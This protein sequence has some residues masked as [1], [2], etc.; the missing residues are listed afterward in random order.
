MS[1]VQSEFPKN[2]DAGQVRGRLFLG[3]FTLSAILAAAVTF[4][5]IADASPVD[6]L[7]GNVPWI[8]IL[9]SIL[10]AVLGMILYGRYRSVQNSEGVSGDDQLAKRFVRLFSLSAVVPALVMGV[11]LGATVTRG[12][13]TWFSDRVDVLVDRNAAIAEGNRDELIR[14]LDLDTKLFADDLAASADDLYQRKVLLEDYLRFQSGYRG[15][16]EAALITRSGERFAVASFAPRKTT[17]I[18]P[19]DVFAEAD[20]GLVA[21]TLYPLNADSMVAATLIKLEGDREHYLYLHRPFPRSIFAQLEAA[22]TAKEELDV[23]KDKTSRLQLIFAIGYA[24]MSALVLLLAARFGLGAA[25]RVT[26]PI[27]KLASA[28]HAVRD[29]DLSV[30]VT[31]P[32]GNDEVA[33]LTRSF[34]GMTEQLGAQRSA[35]IAAREDAEDRRQFVETLLSEV[36]AGVIRTDENLN[37]TLANR[38]AG[39][40]LNVALNNGD[41]IIDVAPEFQPYVSDALQRVSSIDASIDLMRDGESRHFRLKVSPDPAG[42]C[43]LTFDDATRLVSAQRQLAWRDVARRIAHE[44]RNPLTPIQLSTERL[45]RR[46]QS[47]ISQ[48]DKVF[49]RC[50]ETILRQVGDIDRMVQEFS[51]FARMPKPSV[52][53][54]DLRALLDNA[55][56][57]QSMT[58]P[59]I[60]TTVI[61]ESY[62]GALNHVGDERL[63]GQAFGNLI[64]NAAE[65]IAGLPE[66]LEVIGTIDV[67][68]EDGSEGTWVVIEDNGRGFPDGAR[69]KL[70]EPYVTT[71]EKG[72]GLGLAIV[73]RI[74]MD[75][76]GSISL[77]N[78]SDAR[79]G[80]R[81]RVFLPFAEANT[82]LSV[83]QPPKK[84]EVPAYGK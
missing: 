39:E 23:A 57:A 62:D 2:I 15:F 37:I 52:A 66:E 43:V 44:I 73:N 56:F 63:L 51:S 46:Y 55:A 75:H 9:N 3:L 53:E 11:L 60:Q 81:V 33:Q 12:I 21:Q 8:L 14:T 40:L 19:E 13:Q 59:D 25:S 20:D 1:F 61:A 49:G 31:Q 36:S 54:F 41:G 50:V 76:G 24:Q 69:D 47:S 34:N 26:A 83:I 38:S 71:R 29:G 80:A 45:R 78:R 17:R 6:P 18:P 22:S 68:I 79:R 10:I 77:Q 4:F 27:G 58:T 42:G 65:S 16:E 32:S 28:A 67:S 7:S 72:T 5:A 74:I 48:D 82:S 30:R 84:V 35:L 70:L 64:K